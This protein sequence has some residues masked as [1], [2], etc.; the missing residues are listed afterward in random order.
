ML[1]PL[2]GVYITCQSGSTQFSTSPSSC[3]ALTSSAMTEAW[4]EEDAWKWDGGAVGDGYGNAGWHV[5]LRRAWGWRLDEDPK[6][7]GAETV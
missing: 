5:A 2:P 3:I 7:R 1:H 4:R 6:S